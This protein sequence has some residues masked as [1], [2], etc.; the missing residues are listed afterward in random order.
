MTDYELCDT[1]WKLYEAANK[2]EEAAIDNVD[3]YGKPQAYKA[4]NAAWDIFKA[5]RDS[6][7]FCEKGRS[8]HINYAKP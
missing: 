8:V 6:C 1:A 2:L 4:A 5:H 7:P 3:E